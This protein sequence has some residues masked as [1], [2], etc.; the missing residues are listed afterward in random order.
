MSVGRSGSVG[1][2]LC[3]TSV[4]GPPPEHEWGA[5]LHDSSSVNIQQARAEAKLGTAAV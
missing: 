2:N 1:D 4:R 3:M 5:L